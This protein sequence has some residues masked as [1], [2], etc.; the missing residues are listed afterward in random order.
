MIRFQTPTPRADSALPEASHHQEK[1]PSTQHR[2]AE[3]MENSAVTE[4]GSQNQIPVPPGACLQSPQNMVP[5][6]HL[7]EQP[8]SAQG[9]ADQQRA[10][11][12]S[13]GR[14]CFGT[15]DPAGVCKPGPKTVL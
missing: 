9:A 5:A 3:V 15:G 7:L 10:C 6:P 12:Q 1:N 8:P 11:S 4:S 2:G 14:A 13:T